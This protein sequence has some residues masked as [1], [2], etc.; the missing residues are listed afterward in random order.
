[1]N[2]HTEN[3]SW[4]KDDL[5]IRLNASKAL[6]GRWITTSEKKSRTRVSLKQVIM[7]SKDLGKIYDRE[8]FS[9][10]RDHNQQC[11]PCCRHDLFVNFFTDREPKWMERTHTRYCP[12][13]SCDLN[14]GSIGF[15]E[16]QGDLNRRIARGSWIRWQD[17]FFFAL[18]F[19]RFFGD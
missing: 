18:T 4:I 8:E 19:E 1:M 17:A 15:L 16:R 6:S 10:E 2:A 13:G 11:L 3:K 14:T 12:N 9:F 5:C 7:D